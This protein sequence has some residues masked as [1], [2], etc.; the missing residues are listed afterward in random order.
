MRVADDAQVKQDPVVTMFLEKT[1]GLR[2]RIRALRLFG[3]R[4]RDDWRPDSDYDILVVVDRRE[5]ALED[6]LYDAVLD[7]LFETD[8]L[9]SLKIFTEEQYQRLAAIPT[10]FMARVAA[11]GVPLG[12]DG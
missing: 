1:T 8:R 2:D 3:S 12:F 10:P 7:V 6:Q 9:I 4:V 11:E 5:R